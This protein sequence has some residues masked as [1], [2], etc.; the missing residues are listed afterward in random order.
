MA[1]EFKIEWLTKYYQST[2]PLVI[3]D[4]GAY[5]GNEALHFSKALPNATIYSFEA[6]PRNIQ[7]C[8]RN[9]LNHP[10]IHLTHAAVSDL[11]GELQ[12]HD[13]VGPHDGSGSILKPL[14]VIFTDYPGMQFNPPQKV[15]AIRL[16]TFCQQN[17]I[18]H[19]DFIH[20]DIQGAEKRTLLGLGS[21]RPR[22]IYME[23]C[24]GGLYQDAQSKIA[25]DQFMD[26]LGY[27]VS[28]NL[29]YDTLYRRK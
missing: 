17:K 6:S 18:P 12:F 27:T 1:T 26:S 28:E 29:K 7:N 19:V 2:A 20:M 13:S 11:D 24:A 14:P 22:L 10:R 23:T 9:L 25:L 4:L 3:F 16:D 15:A 8:R 5:N 21:F